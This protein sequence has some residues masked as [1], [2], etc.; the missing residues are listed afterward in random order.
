MKILTCSQLKEADQYTIEND[1]IP[2]IDLMEKAARKIT[3][4]I[5]HYWD[6]THNIVVFAGPGNNG[7]DALAVA[8][9][10]FEKEYNVYVYL[11]NVTGKLSEDCITNI[12]RLS[13]CGFTNYTEV[14]NSV[15]FQ[16][17]TESDV[18]IDGLFGTGINKPLSKGFALVVNMINSSGA[19]VVSIDIP[20]GLMGEDNSF[21]I[22]QNIIQ[23][24]L[25]L[26]I[27]LPK[28]SFLFPE[29]ADIVG[30]WELLDIGISQ[31]YIS[32]APSKNFITEEKE[33]RAMI[34][35]RKKFAHKGNFG[36]G[37]I[38]AGSYGMG[39]AAVL[40]AQACV[41]SGIG[42]LT[43][44][45]P[46]CNHN[47]L[48]TM[49][50]T[51]LVQD[52]VDERYFSSPTDLDF[53]QTAAIGPGLGQE[54]ITVEGTL[55]MISESQMPIVIDADALNILSTYRDYLSNIP[56][57]SILTPHVKE[58]ERITGRCS[59][60]YERLAKAKEIAS[61]YQI[62]IILKG[63]WSAVI[64]PDNITY[65]NPT[66]NPGMATGGSGDVL[67]GILTALLAQG[68]SSAEACRLGTYV[69]G[70]AGD[71][72]CSRKGEISMTASDIIEALPEAWT[73]L[74][75]NRRTK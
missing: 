8:R 62:Y 45:T 30:K 26:S 60:N 16:K 71:I 1:E 32:N 4:R 3:E 75:N 48:Q 21:N 14:V 12:Q 28:L 57:N 38:I 46:I 34:K 19:Q 15:N 65:F 25:T 51:A 49:V 20:S 54:D 61:K 73:R 53:Y 22:R 31:E 36:H 17:L 23:A 29:N 24:D 66:G 18:V 27:Q 52:D 55:D 35:P 63:A 42:L 43:V 64:T 69:H 10:L 47:L 2:S 40:A 58:L 67:T 5:C 9:M 37:L 68:Y 56:I 33:I 70:L 6:K 50:P 39:G 11:F 44:H 41:K 72:A 59:N 7:G 74:S 13:D